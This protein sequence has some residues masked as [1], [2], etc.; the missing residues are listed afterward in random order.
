MAH[1]R[2]GHEVEYRVL[3]N[4][5]PD[6]GSFPPLEDGDPQVVGGCRLL[7]RL[8]SG[9]MGRVYLSHTPGGRARSSTVSGWSSRA[10]TAR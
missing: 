10:G 5:G 8:G 4:G 3:S 2:A 1:H 6:A 9:G 7:A